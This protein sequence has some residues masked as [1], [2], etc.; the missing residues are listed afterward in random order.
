MD[1]SLLAKIPPELRNEVYALVL[2]QD[3]EVEIRL[4]LGD[5][6]GNY[7]PL[8]VTPR[9]GP[10]TLTCICRQIQRET[11][12]LFFSTN[13]FCIILH[14]HIL[15][16]PSLPCPR[17]SIEERCKAILAPLHAFTDA[18]TP[19]NT[20]AL[21]S[22]TLH[23]GNGSYEDGLM[24]EE[25][26]DIANAHV[27]T[28]V[29]RT[30]RDWTRDAT[31]LRLILKLGVNFRPLGPGIPDTSLVEL[32]IDL[33]RAL[34]SLDQGVQQL[35]CQFEKGKVSGVECGMMKETIKGWRNA[36]LSG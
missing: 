20:T 4:P 3:A 36:V 12:G 32:V 18:I 25:V 30:L 13:S 27:I 1:R 33:R 2:Q 7:G 17:T 5:H 31:N 35:Q 19:A 22:L 11:A 29:L 24:S 9:R 10:L 34:Q 16:Y 14:P 26:T 6:P 15:W 21:A 8:Q 23:L 28:H